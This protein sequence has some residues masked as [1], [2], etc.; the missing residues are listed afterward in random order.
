[1]VYPSARVALEKT[2]HWRVVPKRLHQLDH[3]IR[4]LDEHNAHTVFWQIPKRANFTP[5]CIGTGPYGL[6]KVR[7]SNGADVIK[8][9]HL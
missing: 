1:M 8:L 7:H 6:R 5:Q 3:R 4:K 2:C 9:L